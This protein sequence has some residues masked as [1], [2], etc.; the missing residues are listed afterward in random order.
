MAAIAA[1]SVQA[2][3]L[4]DEEV[5]AR[6]LAGETPL[7]EIVMRRH[8]QRLYRAVRAIVRDEAEA[9]DIVQETYV[10]AYRSL[11]QFEA[12][13]QLS[14]WLTRIA[15]NEALGRLRKTARLQPLEEM[16]DDEWVPQH[17]AVTDPKMSPESQAAT[18][19]LR[20]L[21][22]STIDQ[23]P[24]M[25][26]QVFMLRAVEGLSTEETAESLGIEADNVKTRL[27]RARAMIRQALARQAQATTSEAFLF[28]A[29]RCDR[30]V[31]GVFQQIGVDPSESE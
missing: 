15:V 29:T 10:R 26:R 7:Y 21:L 8:N 14:T 20:T 13:A 18:S 25:Y 24:V 27:H 23:L 5:V 6:V 17:L 16:V 3:A 4:S 9:E 1:G 22:E 19:E 2:Q 12:R 30:V 31:R 28:P 11:H